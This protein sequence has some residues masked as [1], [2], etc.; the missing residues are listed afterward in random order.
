M[1]ARGLSIGIRKVNSEVCQAVADLV[2]GKTG[3]D[4]Q[5]AEVTGVAGGCINE[6]YCLSAE[7]GGARVFVKVNQASALPMFEAESAGLAEIAGS[8][9]IRVPEPLGVGTAGGFSFFCLEFIE[10][11]PRGNAGA[12]KKMG[13]QLAA[14]HRTLSPDSRFGWHRD[15]T[16]GETPQINDW[17]ENWA[18][19]F[20]EHRLR[21]QF[22]L[23]EKKG[24]SFPRARDLLQLIPSVFEGYEPEPSLLHGDLWGGNAGFDER[25]EPVVFDPA[26]YFGD[27]ETDLA[28]TELFGGFGSAFYEGYASCWPLDDGYER[29]K[30]LYKLY[31]VLNHYNLFGG[32]YA[33]QAERMMAG[34]LKSEG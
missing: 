28:F 10:L 15:N 22:E 12:Q 3:L 18:G 5:G 8:A 33:A 29:R 17:S 13:A 11:S 24:R 27:R 31:H 4:F 9:T 14:M 32:G 2:R 30:T 20:C 19:F 26:V 34:I 16:I 23:A 25:G 1:A 21:Y 7:V 6:A